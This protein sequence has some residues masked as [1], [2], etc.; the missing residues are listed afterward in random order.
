[1]A[2][3][4]VACFTVR[5]KVTLSSPTVEIEEF[6]PSVGSDAM[7]VVSAVVVAV[8]ESVVVVA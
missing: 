3:A 2:A 7:V 4:A 8:N 1:M 5:P 6:D